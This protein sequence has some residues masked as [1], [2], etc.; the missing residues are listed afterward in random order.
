MTVAWYQTAWTTLTL[1]LSS[2]YTTYTQQT[3]VD[4]GSVAQLEKLVFLSVPTVGEHPTSSVMVNGL[5]ALTPPT[6]IRMVRCVTGQ[7]ISSA[8]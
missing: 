4:F 1:P 2:P 5:S 7:G 3:A 8:L 6:N